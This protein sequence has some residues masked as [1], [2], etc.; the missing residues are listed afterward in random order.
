MII[1]EGIFFYRMKNW[2]LVL[3]LLMLTACT[4]SID[5]IKTEDMIGEDVTVFGNVENTIKIG[6]LSGYTLTDE[7]GSI[8]VQSEA[9]P[10]EGDSVRVSG[11]LRRTLLF[12][13]YVEAE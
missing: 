12:G 9:L 10:A 5:S 13:Y 11:V 1:S 2:F 8:A 6:D 4:Q 7:T 3:A